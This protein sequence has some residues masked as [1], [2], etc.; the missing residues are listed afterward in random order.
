MQP[1]LLGSTSLMDIYGYAHIVKRIRIC[2]FEMG[3]Y[4]SLCIKEMRMAFIL[5]KHPHKYQ[6]ITKSITSQGSSRITKLT[7]KR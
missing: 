4:P 5:L 7:T 1:K 6:H 3:M 2:F